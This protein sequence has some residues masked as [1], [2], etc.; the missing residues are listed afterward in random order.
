MVPVVCVMIVAPVVVASFVVVA[1]L[2]NV[3]AVVHRSR[4]GALH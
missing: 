2:M 4:F 3:V 1:A